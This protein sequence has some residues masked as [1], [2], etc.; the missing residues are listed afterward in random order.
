VFEAISDIINLPGGAIPG[1]TSLDK[2]IEALPPEAL[3]KPETMQYAK[4][5]TT[6]R[7]T[8]RSIGVEVVSGRGKVVAV[9]V[10][11]ALY[12]GSELREWHEE[13]TSRY[14]SLKSISS[15]STSAP[16]SA[17]TAQR[18]GNKAKQAQA[19]SKRFNESDK[20]SSTL[21]KT[22]EC[23]ITAVEELE[24]DKSDQTALL[25]HILK[26]AAND[27][28]FASIANRDPHPLLGEAFEMLEKRFETH[29]KQQQ[30]RQN[31]TSMTI[32]SL[33]RD[34]SVSKR[35]ALTELYN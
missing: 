29:E 3:I 12:S 13:A 9:C 27:F 35:Q 18:H 15:P 19:M 14:R 34:L 1:P 5:W 10:I 8:L 17:P 7:S 24:I 16:M 11:N 25:H 33:Q 32:D 20:Y 30:V 28:F 6:L 4:I 21:A 2:L 22:R 31:L 23:Y 26:G